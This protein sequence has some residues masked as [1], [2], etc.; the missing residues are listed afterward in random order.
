MSTPAT[1]SL[2]QRIRG[3]DVITA[4]R[5]PITTGRAELEAALARGAYDHLYVDGQHTAFSDDQ[6][7]AFCALAEEL[8]Y[9]VQFRIPHTRHTYLIGRYLDLGPLAILVPEVMEESTVDEAI[10]FSYYPPVGKRSWGGEAR[11][12]LTALGDRFSRLTYAAWWNEQVVLALQ[13]ESVEAVVNARQLAKPGVDYVAFGP[14]DLSFS[15]EA[16]PRFPF[17]TPE[18]CARHVC[19]QLR[20]TDVRVGIATPVGPEERQRYL[21]MGVTLFQELPRR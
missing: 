5:V 19:E 10:A 4:L 13:I 11:Y 21:E 14:N 18:E 9:P 8:G 15:L 16:H 1:P 2:K 6:L 12:G 17:R 7:V 3:G 20:D